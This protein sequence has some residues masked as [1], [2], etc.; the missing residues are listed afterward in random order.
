MVDFEGVI[1]EV[2]VDY[3]N[4]LPAVIIVGL[5]DAAVQESRERTNRGK[6]AGYSSAPPHRGQPP[7]RHPQQDQLCDLPIALGRRHPRWISSARKH[8]RRHVHW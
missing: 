4:G 8:R 7:R 6:N 1:V 2:E 3:T 5:P